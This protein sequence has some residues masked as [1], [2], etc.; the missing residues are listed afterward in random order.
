MVKNKKCVLCGKVIVV[1][2]KDHRKIEG[3]SAHNRCHRNTLTL[4]TGSKT[5]G[6]YKDFY[7]SGSKL[8]R[9]KED[10]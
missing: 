2:K 1:A 8:Y 3:G 9:R 10:V 6:K 7:W 5:W 4:Q